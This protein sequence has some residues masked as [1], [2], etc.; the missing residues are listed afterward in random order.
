M[1]TPPIM[2]VDVV[3][4]RPQQSQHLLDIETPA[5]IAGRLQDLG[6]SLQT[7]RNAAEIACAVARSLR[8][9][10]L[11]RTNWGE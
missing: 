9:G 2:S 1:K 6:Y 8:N 3:R 5:Q 11:S 7:A 10:R 4:R